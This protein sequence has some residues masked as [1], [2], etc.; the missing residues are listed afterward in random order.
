M[1]QAL[2]LGGKSKSLKNK[3]DGSIKNMRSCLQ[4]QLEITALTRMAV[5]IL[6]TKRILK[7][8]RN[9]EVKRLQ[10]TAGIV[11]KK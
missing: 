8:L 1:I 11:P 5:E 7:L 10:R 2:R 3:C 4:Y 6:F 9:I